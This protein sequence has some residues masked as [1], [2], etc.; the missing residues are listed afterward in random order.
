VSILLI[1]MRSNNSC[2]LY[3]K[4]SQITDLTSLP[5]A[6]NVSLTRSSTKGLQPPQP[7]VA[8]DLL[9]TSDTFLHSPLS[10]GRQMF[11]FEML[12]HEQIWAVAGK[13]STLPNAKDCPPL[14]GTIRHSGLSGNFISLRYN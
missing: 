7:V 8:L 14:T 5:S 2:R 11:P 13:S 3:S 10:T 12:S 4:C 1:F 6:F 9:M